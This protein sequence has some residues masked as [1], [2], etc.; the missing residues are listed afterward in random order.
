[1][2][3]IKRNYHHYTRLTNY[4]T[5]LS[6][7]INQKTKLISTTTSAQL[8]AR[9]KRC[10]WSLVEC[11]WTPILNQ[12][13]K[14]RIIFD[15]RD[16]NEISYWNFYSISNWR[17]IWRKKSKKYLNPSKSNAMNWNYPNQYI[18]TPSWSPYHQNGQ[19]DHQGI[20]PSF[21]GNDIKMCPDPD[22]SRRLY[23]PALMKE[24]L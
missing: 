8:K 24:P 13:A 5:N 2:R 18:P 16:F 4:Q 9:F 6:L 23:W 20:D 12:H 7:T 22:G 1:M 21:T 17:L 14:T 19:F 3:A 11:V 10:L 15:H